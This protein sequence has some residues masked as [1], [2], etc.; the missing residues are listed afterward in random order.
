MLPIER[1]GIEREH[2]DY[3]LRAHFDFVVSD[4]NHGP[5]FAVEFDG[6]SHDDEEQKARDAKK[7]WLARHFRCR[8]CESRRVILVSVTG[9]WTS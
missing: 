8:C 5:L 2:Y 9:T 6:P 7:D 4:S 1:S 3:A